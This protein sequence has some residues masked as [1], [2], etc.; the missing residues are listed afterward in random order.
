MNGGLSQFSTGKSSVDLM[1]MAKDPPRVK[2]VNR[3]TLKTRYNSTNV[4]IFKAREAHFDN[5]FTVPEAEESD[6]SPSLVLSPLRVP[7]MHRLVP[8]E[9]R[10]QKTRNR[11]TLANFC[12]I[13]KDQVKY[14]N[15]YQSTEN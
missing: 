9:K 13:N 7:V 14:H 1:A 15:R 2:A 12:R 8:Y 5:Q 6:E 3:K 4:S 11:N 10:A